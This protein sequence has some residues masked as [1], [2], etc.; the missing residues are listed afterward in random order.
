[1]V[2]SPIPIATSALL[3]SIFECLVED[4]RSRATVSA[5]AERIEVAFGEVP[6]PGQERCLVVY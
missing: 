3:E 1:M 6:V 4:L 2:Q 5:L